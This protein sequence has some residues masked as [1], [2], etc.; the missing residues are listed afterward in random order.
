MK[1][2]LLNRLFL[3]GLLAF[4][5]FSVRADEEQDLIGTLQSTAGAPR[6]A[7]PVCG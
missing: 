2:N 1:T 6:N 5:A 3:A 4:A 7:P